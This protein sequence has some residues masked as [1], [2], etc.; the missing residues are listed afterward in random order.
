MQVTTTICQIDI[1]ILILIQ[2]LNEI[3]A[4]STQIMHDRKYE[5]AFAK[6]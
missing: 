3:F 1:K 5:E 2:S 6:I 4:S